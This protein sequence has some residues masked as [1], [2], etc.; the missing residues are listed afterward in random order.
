MSYL[1]ITAKVCLCCVCVDWHEEQRVT[2]PKFQ[3]G[4]FCS[5]HENHLPKLG[6]RHVHFQTWSSNNNVLYY[7]IIDKPPAAIAWQQ[8]IQSKLAINPRKTGQCLAGS[9][10]E[11]SGLQ[12]CVI[13]PLIYCNMKHKHIGQVQLINVRD[14]RVQN[15]T[16]FKV[17]F[18]FT[19]CR[20]CVS[21]IT[22]DI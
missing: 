8:T 17:W 10:C 22:S 13:H 16:I 6:G 18:Q 15:V 20:F 7:H 12:S 2:Q 5:G 4:K 14:M 3:T 11:M 21:S 9:F 19:R 1:I